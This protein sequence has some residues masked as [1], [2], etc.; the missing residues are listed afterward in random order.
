MLG[1]SNNQSF[2]IIGTDGG[3]LEKPLSVKRL[4]I[5]SG[6]RMEILVNL[7]GMEGQN[8][9]LMSYASELPNGI[10][11]ATNP[12][13]SPMMMLHEY[14]PNL[15]NGTNFSLLQLNI[16]VKN[17]KPVLQI[18]ETLVKVN[19]LDV[20]N[21]NIQR[22]F[23]FSP[24]QM[25]MNQL[26]NPFLI[27]NLSFDMERINFTVPLGKTEVW[28]LRNQSAISHP[29]H[30]HDVQFNIL[31]RNGIPP[32]AYEMGRK[33]VV[34][35]RPGETVRII[36]QFLDYSHPKIP[37]MY[38][39]HLLSH[40]DDGM[41]GQFLVE[42]TSATD[43][44]ETSQNRFRLYPNPFANKIYIECKDDSGEEGLVECSNS[45]GQ[46][47]DKAPLRETCDIAFLSCIELDF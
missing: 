15:L 25:G 16:K 43:N 18:P 24:S 26:N 40:E 3:L 38:H 35:V 32:T 44:T 8:V 14:N 21:S 23:L 29:F 13:M 17:D 12:G 45:M 28:E 37:Y 39:C 2:S 6:E 1:L 36:M 46:I 20:S 34:M 9:Q 19:R 22:N 11:G 30:V 5:S 33:D 47:V 27:N 7:T 10:F 4:L 31:S 41:M 42:S